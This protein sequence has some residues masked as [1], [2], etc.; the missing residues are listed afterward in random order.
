MVG[1][2]QDVV[3]CDDD[4]T[5]DLLTSAGIETSMWQ[6]KSHLQHCGIHMTWR[7]AEDRITRNCIVN[8]ATLCH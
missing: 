5:W 1:E 3:V 7:S 4:K 2:G 6:T 8:A